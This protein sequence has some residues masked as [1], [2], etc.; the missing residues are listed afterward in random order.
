MFKYCWCCVYTQWVQRKVGGKGTSGRNW[1][2]SDNYLSTLSLC[3][4]FSQSFG[5]QISCPSV[6]GLPRCE[7]YLGND[8]PINIA[9]ASYKSQ[10]RGDPR[11]LHV[12][13]HDCEQSKQQIGLVMHQKQNKGSNHINENKSNQHKNKSPESAPEGSPDPG[14][15]QRSEVL[16]PELSSVRVIHSKAAD[17]RRLLTGDFLLLPTWRQAQAASGSAHVRCLLPITDHPS[18]VLK[19]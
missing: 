12:N 1:T 8:Y 17:S 9:Y 10:T 2:L 4:N 3:L 18:L 7:H 14:R 5:S 15:V 13:P 19:V 16:S 11:Q 6:F